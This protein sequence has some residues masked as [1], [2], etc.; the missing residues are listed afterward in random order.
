MFMPQRNDF[1][2]IEPVI[3][4]AQRMR[5][6]DDL[7]EAEVPIA[8]ENLAMASR[9]VMADSDMSGWF[10][11]RVEPRMEHAVKN[12]LVD[13]DIEA[14]VP[15]SLPYEF[16]CRGRVKMVCDEPVIRGYVLVRCAV[17][18]DAFLGL[19]AVKG[20]SGIV[21]GTLRPWRAW[22]KEVNEYRALL[23][24]KQEQEA[25]EPVF[26]QHDAV[27]VRLGPFGGFTGVIVQLTKKRARV[28]VSLFGR[29]NE[30]NI[31]LAHIQKL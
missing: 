24:D 30:V 1:I 23:A 5:L 4:W 21:G 25:A 22:D 10:C 17:R 19:Q 27:A 9:G 15:C 6:K 16:P 8:I 20:V 29:D 26:A 13:N 28:R 3:T 31:P 11:L 18:Q 12:F 2:A 7:R 14:W